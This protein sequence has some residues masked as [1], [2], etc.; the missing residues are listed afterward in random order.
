M[1]EDVVGTEQAYRQV[2]ELAP[3]PHYHASTNLGMQLCEANA[4]RK[5]ALS[6]FELAPEHFPNDPLLHFN[7]AVVL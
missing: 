7:R 2:I 5:E 6:V 1:G 3:R 4:R